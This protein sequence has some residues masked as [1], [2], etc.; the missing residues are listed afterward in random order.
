MNQ[1]PLQTNFFKK[2]GRALL[3]FAFCALL[4]S[5]ASIAFAKAK[6][7]TPTPPIENPPPVS[8][9]NHQHGINITSQLSQTK[10]LQNSNQELVLEVSIQTP[11]APSDVQQRKPVDMVVILDRSSSMNG[12]QKFPLAKKAISSLVD[13]LNSDDRISLITFSNDAIVRL[14]LKFADK[15]CQ[16]EM[17]QVLKTL[18]PGGST[19]M[20]RG[21]QLAQQQLAKTL[22]GHNRR[23]ILLSDG[24]ANAGIHDPSGLQSLVKTLANQDV[25]VSTIGMG[26][27]FNENVMSSLA[28]HGMGSFS[29]LEHLA[30][31][32]GLF[33]KD[34][35]DARQ[36]YTNFSQLL[37]NLP[38]G[39][40]IVDAG[41]YPIETTSNAGQVSIPL[42]QLLYGRKKSLMVSFT[43]PTQQLGK[44]ELGHFQLNYKNPEGELFRLDSN[45]DMLIAI[46][47]PEKTQEVAATIN[48]DVY[49][50]NWFD[51]SFGRLQKSISESLKSGNQKAAVLHIQEYE[52]ALEDAAITSGVP[53]ESKIIDQ[54]IMSLK[55]EVSQSFEGDLAEQKLKQ[56]RYAKKNLEAGRAS[57]RN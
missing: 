25:V 39:I 28:D 2:H 38:A 33:E 34:L 19:N 49:Q 11:K 24:Q 29:Y 27:G 8:H 55:E 15:A 12:D 52:E 23:V 10:I 16:N 26:L 43:V 22:E 1:N 5:I 21:L 30:G 41:G 36:Q 20:G 9:Q 45:H 53:L 35:N 18:H 44:I 40:K 6:Q 17:E 47:E 4:S 46:V 14:P 54:Q 42:G 51:N 32:D 31:L 48:K 57:Q 13:L 37:F 3:V 7:V 50:R 56:N